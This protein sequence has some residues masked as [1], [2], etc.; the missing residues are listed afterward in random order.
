MVEALVVQFK[1]PDKTLP[2]LITL[3]A[4]QGF[5]TDWPL[6]PVS[7]GESPSNQGPDG[8]LQVAARLVKLEELE[9]ATPCDLSDL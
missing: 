3:A 1:D 6:Q 5:F 8:K 7:P 4:N 2:P 9:V